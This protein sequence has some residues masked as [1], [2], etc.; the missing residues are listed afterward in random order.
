[1]VAI[2]KVR[3]TPDLRVA[4]ISISTLGEAAERDAALAGLR[5]AASFLRRRLGEEMELRHVPELTFAHDVELQDARRVDSLLRGLR[6][7][8]GGTE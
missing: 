1:M 2:T 3:M 6:E 5:S 8:G 4:R 7:R